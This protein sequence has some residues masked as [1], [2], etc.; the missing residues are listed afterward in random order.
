LKTL[1]YATAGVLS[2]L[3]AV[4]AFVSPPGAW[5]LGVAAVSCLIVANLD[6]FT[7][8]S[9][10][11]TG[12]RAVLRDA[13]SQL[14]ELA[15][16]S[17]RLSAAS[18]LALV[19]RSGRLGGFSDAEQSTALRD[20]IALLREAGVG[21]DEIRA[22][23]AQSWDRFVNF[24]YVHA[25][26]GS[27][28]A[29][30]F[31]DPALREEWKRLRNFENPATPEQLEDFLRRVG[32]LNGLRAELLAGY[33]HYRDHGEHLR[34]DLWARRREIPPIPRQPA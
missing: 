22:I 15:R 6:R 30:A 5:P 23:K 26:T 14:D 1:L 27:S 17:A 3:M 7:E 13:K 25:I 18:N 24:D 9:A 34:A 8:I 20:S 19:Q 31:D 11:A 16:N 32:A 10:T 29:P 21:E 4:A 2:A 12:V 28:Q 33:R